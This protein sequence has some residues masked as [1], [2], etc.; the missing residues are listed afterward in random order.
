MQTGSFIEHFSD[1]E[2]P[3]SHINQKHLFIDIL[4][5][6]ICAG[7]CGAKGWNDVEEFGK[8]R[9]KWLKKFLELPHGIPSHDTFRTVFL[10]L[11]T[12]K[13]MECFGNWVSCIVKKVE[14]EIISI[15]GK[16]SKRSYSE[17]KK[18][19]HMVSAWANKNSLVLT[20]VKVDEKSNE[21]TAI[22][23]ILRSLEIKG[24]LITIDAMGCQKEIAK[25]IKN[26]G[27]DYIL[28]L[29]GNHSKLHEE[30][31][32]YIDTCIE[33]NFDEVPH[34]K[35][36]T[37]EKDHGRIETRQYYL[38]SDLNWL[39][40]KKCWMGLNSIGVVVSKRKIGDKTSEERRLYITSLESNVK[41]FA[42]GVRGHWGVENN[43]HWQLDITFNDDQCRKRAEKSA[44]NCAVV[45]HIVLNMLKKETS[46]KGSIS[47]KQFKAALDAN[48]L[49]KVL[50]CK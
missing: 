19:L 21:I 35:H 8:S 31:K 4:F 40:N 3:R 2:D 10:F 38:I 34:E 23:K 1:I 15:D 18:P 33:T 17:N 43:L 29:K 22:P 46:Y 41:K 45:R 6:T 42:Q 27:G 7:I 48:Y 36:K 9:K 37:N 5:I 12:K 39:E 50:E 16:T 25:Q 11:D 14:G 47:R 20:Q 32:E 26:Q 44:E 28:S 13:F 49:E 24:C 30:V